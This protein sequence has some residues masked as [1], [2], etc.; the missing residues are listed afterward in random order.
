MGRYRKG[1]TWA[2]AAILLFI[3]ATSPSHDTAMGVGLGIGRVHALPLPQLINTVT[4]AVTDTANAVTDAAA[5]V[6]DAQVNVAV[7]G[8]TGTTPTVVDEVVVP[9]T[10]QD[11][12]PPAVETPRRQ[13]RVVDG[14][15]RGRGEERNDRDRVGRKR[16]GADRS[17]PAPAPVVNIPPPPP[18]PPV[19]VP[20]TAP[21]APAPNVNTGT[22]TPNAN[23]PP[24][25]APFPAPF[26][27]TAPFPGDLS[28]L[29]A[30]ARRPPIRVNQRPQGDISATAQ[31]SA[32]TSP[33]TS[34]PASVAN[35]N[36]PEAITTDPSPASDSSSTTTGSAPTTPDQG[37]PRPGAN[38]LPPFGIP[39]PPPARGDSNRTGKIA[40][41]VGIGLCVSAVVIGSI[42]YTAT[43][44]HR[45]RRSLPDGGD[46]TPRK[47]RFFGRGDSADDV[48]SPPPA[49]DT[50]TSSASRTTPSPPSPLASEFTLSLDRAL[51][52]TGNRAGRKKDHTRSFPPSR[53][54]FT[55]RLSLT[56]ECMKGWGEM[57]P[58]PGRERVGATAPRLDELS[59]DPPPPAKIRSSVRKQ[60]CTPGDIKCIT[61]CYK[62][63]ADW[64]FWKCRWRA[65][66]LDRTFTSGTNGDA[67]GILRRVTFVAMVKVPLRGSLT[68]VAVPELL[69]KA[70]LNLL[71]A[72]I[73]QFR[74]MH[75]AITG[76]SV[77]QGL[78]TFNQPRDVQKVRQLLRV[79]QRLARG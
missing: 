60:L 62:T 54:S 47:R 40:L 35:Q 3:L 41:F 7:D 42:F 2:A 9:T 38:N 69:V 49:Y 68:A 34:S 20:V 21:P 37:Q 79:P 75:L 14:E 13:Q 31:T 39:R 56:P 65:E 64:L 32:S 6:V 16:T 57:D 46:N 5:G 4:S 24:P 67:G 61:S 15:T 50:L 48:K 26:P 12:V 78:E 23:V 76:L 19:N 63:T 11:S 73:A 17:A 66:W 77:M 52:A 51:T 10:A 59:V 53:D 44:A 58:L 72:I 30:T 27:P 43:K 28:S 55:L 25:P 71:C 70:F 33:S 8:E 1:G 18:A 22:T 45:R 29:P 36:G 74:C